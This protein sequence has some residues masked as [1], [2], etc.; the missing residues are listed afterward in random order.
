MKHLSYPKLKTRTKSFLTELL[1]AVKELSELA[2][3][4]FE[5]KYDHQKRLW[6]TM[7]GY[8]PQRISQGLYYLQQKNLIR[9]KKDAYYTVYEL[10]ISGKQKILLSKI[11]M[12]I[13]NSKDGNSC[14]V[15]FDIPESKRNHRRFI[16]RLLLNNGFINLQKSVLIGPNFLPSEFLELLE[17]WKLRQNVTIIKGQ[18][19]NF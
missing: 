15:V 17:E 3:K 1:E 6:R 18:I 14:I 13:R 2:P 10:T 8:P 7:H 16:R 12:G 5:S 11:P 4:P 19:L 9:K